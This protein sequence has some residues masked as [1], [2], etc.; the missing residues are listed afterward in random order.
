MNALA[1]ILVCGMTLSAVLAAV[2]TIYQARPGNNR[3]HCFGALDDWIW[4]LLFAAVVF[5]L[6]AC[7]SLTL[8]M[9]G[10]VIDAVAVL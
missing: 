7:L 3:C 2:L 4:R 1:S 8:A 9:I 10:D 5:G 6:L